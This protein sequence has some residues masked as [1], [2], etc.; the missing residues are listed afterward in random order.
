MLGLRLRSNFDRVST[1]DPWR[2]CSEGIV[3]LTMS[4]F[5]VALLHPEGLAASGN[6]YNL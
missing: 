2:W 4:V 5:S 1:R 6:T 3:H